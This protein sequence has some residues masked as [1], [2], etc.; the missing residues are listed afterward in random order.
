[1]GLFK[2]PSEGAPSSSTQQSASLELQG[3]A[4]L[5]GKPSTATT[6]TSAGSGVL[7]VAAPPS[8]ASTMS[9]SEKKTLA[10]LERIAHINDEAFT[11]PGLGWK[12]GIERWVGV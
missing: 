6:T 8:Q 2:K 5:E 12:F 1:M 3:S 10:H 7:P 4:A 11:V 9:A